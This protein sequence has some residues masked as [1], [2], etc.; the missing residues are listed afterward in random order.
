[1]TTSP[2]NPAVMFASRPLTRRSFIALA[3]AATLG[4]ACTRP[5][6][7]D[8]QRWSLYGEDY[9]AIQ[10]AKEAAVVDEDGTV[11]YSFNADTPMAMASTTKI[12][13]AVVALESG[14]SLD[15]VYT[16]TDVVNTVYGQLAGFQIGEQVTLNDLLH[17]LLVYSGN[18][19]AVSIAECV[20][21]SVA[22]F[23]DMMNAKAAELGLAGT[24]YVNPHGLDEDGHC[25]TALDL[26]ALARHAVQIPLFSSIVGSAY[27]TVV[28]GGETKTLESTDELANT[29]PGMRGVKT[30]FTYNAGNC[31]VG[32]ATLGAKTLFVCVL[33]CEG[34]DMRWADARA[35]L[36]WG[37][38]HFPQTQG[39][40]AQ[41][42]VTYMPFSSNAG[43]SVACT[44]TGAV[45]F[46]DGA[47][48][49]LGAQVSGAGL[50]ETGS[51]V[52]TL[53]WSSGQG[54]VAAARAQKGEGVLFE[55]HAFGPL[56]SGLFY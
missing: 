25:S 22:A 20:A 54:G 16:V 7:A 35:L 15:T 18:D 6:Q 17:A 47:G 11:L 51:V 12:M 30:G 24:H 45:S 53:Q 34:S 8:G 48:H 5:A 46:R 14:L 52:S 9:P 36:D 42:L 21:G 44:S 13:T 49:T 28:A 31:F 1:M 50:A 3:A 37:F 26:I 55:S 43:W 33:G 40:G 10:Y 38:A 27:T 56:N 39:V 29:Y 32:R 19:A 41:S 2:S 4:L 23:V